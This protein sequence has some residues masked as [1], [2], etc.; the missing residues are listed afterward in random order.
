MPSFISISFQTT[1]SHNKL[2]R[3]LTDINKAV[4]VVY[5]TKRHLWMKVNQHIPLGLAAEWII[6]IHKSPPNNSEL[7]NKTANHKRSARKTCLPLKPAF[8]VYPKK[9]KYIP[10]KTRRYRHNVYHNIL[11]TDEVYT[12]NCLKHRP[13]VETTGQYV[14]VHHRGCWIWHIMDRQWVC[15]Y[16]G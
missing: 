12:E 6:S 9:R 16:S 7:I 8:V 4:W 13:E 11:G 15:W 1:L 10:L 3:Y 14:H 5:T 2:L